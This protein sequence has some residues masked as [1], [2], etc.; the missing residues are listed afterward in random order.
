MKV[1]NLPHLTNFDVLQ[2]IIKFGD[3][4]L[5][6]VIKSDKLHKLMALEGGA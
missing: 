2:V 5:K 1:K 3:R 4:H 6:E